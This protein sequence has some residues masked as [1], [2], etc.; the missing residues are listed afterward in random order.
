MPDSPIYIQLR[1]LSL[2]RDGVPLR[3]AR[4]IAGRSDWREAGARVAEC[5]SRPPFQCSDSCA[6]R[7]VND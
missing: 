7:V 1:M 4:R 2:V 6:C 5:V 3:I